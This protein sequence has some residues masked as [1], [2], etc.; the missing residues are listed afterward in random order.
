MTNS[1]LVNILNCTAQLLH[2]FCSFSN[3]WFI[4]LNKSSEI[5]GGTVLRN[6]KRFHRSLI[7]KKLFRLEDELMLQFFHNEELI[8]EAFH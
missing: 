2:Y 6:E 3:T 7:D 8:F 5:L 4:G 1:S